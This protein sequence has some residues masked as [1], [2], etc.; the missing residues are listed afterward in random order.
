MFLDQFPCPRLTC[1]AVPLKALAESLGLPVH[2]VDTF[3]GWDVR[4]PACSLPFAHMLTRAVQM[5]TYN[6]GSINL[7]IAVSFG[8]F[9]PPRLLNAA[10]FGGLN[11]HPSLLPEY[12]P[13]PIKH[14]SDS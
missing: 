8:L 5:P 13:H 3:T 1:A 6:N 4:A 7:I 9:V 11:I 10:K 14:L 2:E 12:V